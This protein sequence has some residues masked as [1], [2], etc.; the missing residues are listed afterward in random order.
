MIG[1][2]GKLTR[3]A[4]IGGVGKDLQPDHS[5]I[6]HCHLD[7][8]VPVSHVLTVAGFITTSRVSKTQ[9]LKTLC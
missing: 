5:L 9:T 6:G 7:G 2:I 8:V 1:V 4:I 3:L